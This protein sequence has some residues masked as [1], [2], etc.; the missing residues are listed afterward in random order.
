LHIGVP[1]GAARIKGKKREF[2]L[3]ENLGTQEAVQYVAKFGSITPIELHEEL[4]RSYPCREEARERAWEIV[5][6][7]EEARERSER[8]NKKGE[9]KE[10]KGDIINLGA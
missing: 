7:Y 4:R 2:N 5:S 9:K 3:W 10:S 1:P 6:L 8:E